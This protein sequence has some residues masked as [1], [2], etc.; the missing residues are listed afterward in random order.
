MFWFEEKKIFSLGERGT[1]TKI[2]HYGHHSKKSNT[3][4]NN[5]KHM[6]VR[7]KNG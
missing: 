1:I 6:K 7:L 5:S 2:C 3:I 4:K